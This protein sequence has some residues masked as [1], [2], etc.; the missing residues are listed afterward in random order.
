M[1]D[2][3]DRAKEDEG[4]LQRLLDFII[5]GFPSYRKRELRRKTDKLLRDYFGELLDGERDKLQRRAA[6]SNATPGTSASLARGLSGV[7]R[8][9]T[10]R[11]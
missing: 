2:L 4:P 9:P 1:S 11:P 10:P 7:T 3:R 6:S 5:P 8:S